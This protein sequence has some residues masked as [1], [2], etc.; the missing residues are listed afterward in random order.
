MIHVMQVWLWRRMIFQF[1]IPLKKDMSATAFS[2]LGKKILLSTSAS[3]PMLII[4]ETK[5]Q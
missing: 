5:R 4:Q 2:L 3:V 1:V